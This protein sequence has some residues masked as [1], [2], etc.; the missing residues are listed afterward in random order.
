MRIAFLGDMALFGCF[1]VRLNSNIKANLQEIASYL[2][3]FDLV[4]GNIGI[5]FFY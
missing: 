1:D 3:S 2:D 4:I 5:S